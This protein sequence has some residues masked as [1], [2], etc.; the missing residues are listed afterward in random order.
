MGT[1]APSCTDM[2][3]YTHLCTASSSSSIWGDGE[4]ITLLL[5]GRSLGLVLHPGEDLREC[6]TL[7]GWRPQVKYVRGRGLLTYLAHVPR[8]YVPKTGSAEGGGSGRGWP[9]VDRTEAGGGRGWGRPIVAITGFPGFPASSDMVSESACLLAVSP[10]LDVVVY[11]S[12]QQTT[13]TMFG[14]LVSADAS[15]LGQVVVDRD[16]DW[17]GRGVLSSYGKTRRGGHRGS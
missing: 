2:D 8:M 13:R 6:N 12:T 11:N 9:F 5:S 14:V 1:L 17:I 16:I 3:S 15:G 4:E 10:P 7:P